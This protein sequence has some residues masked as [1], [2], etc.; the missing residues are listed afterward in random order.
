MPNQATPTKI[1]QEA[2]KIYKEKRIKESPRI[3]P[4]QKWY[5]DLFNPYALKDTSEILMEE[6]DFNQEII[7]SIINLKNN[8][9]IS[10][11]KTDWQQALLSL[12]NHNERLHAIIDNRNVLYTTFALIIVVTTLL[13]KIIPTLYIILAIAALFM[14]PLN[15][16]R[17]KNRHNLMWNK[18]FLNLMEANLDKIAKNKA[19]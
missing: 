16:A 15:F 1:I 6:N 13:A 17:I 5:K 12:K 8:M 4:T 9:G 10:A 2:L 18:E 7:V 11:E 14:F 3:H 19:A